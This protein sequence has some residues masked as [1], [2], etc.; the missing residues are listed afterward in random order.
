MLLLFLGQSHQMSFPGKVEYYSKTG[1]NIGE[2]LLVHYGTSYQKILGYH[3]SLFMDNSCDCFT[4]SMNPHFKLLINITQVQINYSTDENRHHEF[5]VTRLGPKDLK[6]LF[7]GFQRAKER[8]L[9]TVHLKRKLFRCTVC[10]FD[11]GE[12][13]LLIN[14]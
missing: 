5:I 12:L 11:T 13:H 9:E 4:F 7:C 3:P 8:H 1:I 14:N 6:C 2:E 10:A